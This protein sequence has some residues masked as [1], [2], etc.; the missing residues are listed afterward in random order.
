MVNLVMGFA[1]NLGEQSYRVF[2]ESLRR[3]YPTSECDLVIITNRY[4]PFYCELSK[5]GVQFLPTS[6]NYS[7]ETGRTAKLINRIALN[8]MR[9]M[10]KFRLLERIAPEIA[11]AYPNLIENWHHPHFARWFAYERFL[12]LNRHYDQVLLSDVKD[13]VFQAPFFYSQTPSVVSLFDQ[14]IKYGEACWDTK[15]YEEA[16]GTP[17]LEKVSGKSSICIGTIMGPHAGL[18][19]MVRELCCFFSDHPFGKIE[20]A[21]FNYLILTGRLVTPFER[22]DNLVGPITTLCSDAIHSRVIAN[23]GLIFRASEADRPIPV[24]HMYDRYQN[25]RNEISSAFSLKT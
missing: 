5:L 16:F 18:L 22:V 8:F 3:V 11:E 6:N 15:W 10:R 9:G 7:R 1:T 14:G 4:E 23:S 13:V 21:I 25:T 17:E 2:T 24:V 20:Q 12:S 19:S